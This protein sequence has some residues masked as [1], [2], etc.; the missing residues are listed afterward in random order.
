MV[1]GIS[2]ICSNV[3]TAPD[4]KS[5]KRGKKV[6]L[7]LCVVTQTWGR[8]DEK[9]PN[10][11]SLTISFTLFWLPKQFFT[12]L[13]PS[14]PPGSLGRVGFCKGCCPEGAHCCQHLLYGQKAKLFSCSLSDLTTQCSVLSQNAHFSRYLNFTAQEAI[15]SP[16][17]I[18]EPLTVGRLVGFHTLS[19]H[20][21][22]II[23]S[24][25][26]FDAWAPNPFKYKLQKIKGTAVHRI[27]DGKHTAVKFPEEPGIP[28]KHFLWGRMQHEHLVA[29]IYYKAAYQLGTT[30]VQKKPSYL[31]SSPSA[32]RCCPAS[33][34]PN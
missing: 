29:I 26:S 3:P 28:C 10:C 12:L 16:Q 19:F 14:V 30:A 6:E 18:E 13:H 21:W 33:L 1:T 22:Y 4:R 8:R 15:C 32:T 20:N 34:L 27:A 25:V 31:F 2:R 17:C 5:T 11:D 9:R 23:N 7:K 24:N